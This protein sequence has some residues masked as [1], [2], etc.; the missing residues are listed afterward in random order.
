MEICSCVHKVAQELIKICQ[1]PQLEELGNNLVME[2][3]VDKVQD[4]TSHTREVIESATIVTMDIIEQN[5]IQPTKVHT[6]IQ[7]FMD[8][9][10]KDMQTLD[11]NVAMHM[12]T[13]EEL[14]YR[15]LISLYDQLEI[16]TIYLRY[17]S[18]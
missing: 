18:P 10:S 9:L 16:W 8:T 14:A 5:L 13:I 2:E 1:L 7:S 4:N 6:M 15:K 12:T 17:K 3:F 11:D